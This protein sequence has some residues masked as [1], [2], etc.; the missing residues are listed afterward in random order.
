MNEGFVEVLGRLFTLHL[1]SIVFFPVSLVITFF[2]NSRTHVHVQPYISKIE[3]NIT[4][5]NLVGFQQGRFAN[6]VR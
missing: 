3:R 5:F 4:N 2:F 1:D 6:M